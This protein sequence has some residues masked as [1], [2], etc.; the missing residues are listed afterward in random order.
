M[1]S[2][3]KGKVKNSV[4]KKPLNL[5]ATSLFCLKMVRK[6][7]GAELFELIQGFS[8]LVI[9][10]VWFGIKDKPRK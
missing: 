6:G 1:F 2:V 10:M 8:P 4:G 5:L 3:K 9:N 7:I